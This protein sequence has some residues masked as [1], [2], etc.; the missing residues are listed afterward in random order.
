MCRGVGAILQNINTWMGMGS[1][2]NPDTDMQVT[3]KERANTICLICHSCAGLFMFNQFEFMCL[4][5]ANHCPL[6]LFIRAY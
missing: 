6:I 2:C 3:Q 1:F 5:K 4:P